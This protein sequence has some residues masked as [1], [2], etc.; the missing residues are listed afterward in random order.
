MAKKQTGRGGDSY[1]SPAVMTVTAIKGWLLLI[2]GGVLSFFFGLGL[3]LIIIGY[4]DLDRGD[5]GVCLGMLIPSIL[6]LWLGIRQRQRVHLARRYNSVFLGM[7]GGE[8]GMEEL[9]E[10]RGKPAE[11]VARELETLFTKGFFR[12]CTLRRGRAAAVLLPEER[13][14]P[15]RF[16]AVTCPNC[17]ATSTLPAGSRG[18]C[19]YCGSSIA[20][21]E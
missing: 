20:A 11:Q 17:G 6:L 8:A 13:S 4:S 14:A 18:K 19:E 21:E 5:L 15:Q 2:V 16:V 3:L 10:Q 9:A 7:G 12:G 1:L